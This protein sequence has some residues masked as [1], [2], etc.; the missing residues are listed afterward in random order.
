M[1][2]ALAFTLTAHTITPH[3][4]GMRISRPQPFLEAAAQAMGIAQLKVIDTG[5]DP[6]S[7]PR[8][9]WDDASNALALGS[10][11]AVCYERNTETN[12]RLEAAGVEVI[13]IPGSE[14]GSLRGGPR[15]MCCPVTRD[16]ATEQ[17]S[18]EMPAITGELAS[19]REHPLLNADVEMADA[20]TN[21]GEPVRPCEQLTPGWLSGWPREF[22][23][24]HGAGSWP[25]PTRWTVQAVSRAS[26]RVPTG[27]PVTRTA[28]W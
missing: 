17:D 5:L 3:A 24:G 7:A 26:W 15:C 2:P 28:S 4:E 18:G 22:F 13:R 8:R 21:P 19:I 1:Y 14:L 20:V 12:A 6:L 16:P 9:Q 10:R 23:G 11:V 27:S 25:R